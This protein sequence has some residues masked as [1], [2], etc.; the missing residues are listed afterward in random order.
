[1]ELVF[2]SLTKYVQILFCVLLFSCKNSTPSG[3]KDQIRYN[4]RCII[5]DASQQ[6][7]S[8]VL[9]TVYLQVNNLSAKSIVI[10]D[11]SGDYSFIADSQNDLIQKI[12]CVRCHT[13]YL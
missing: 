4:I 2:S 3:N 7:D 8:Q 6:R 13:E 9:L 5:L 12:H 1:M 11:R 10:S